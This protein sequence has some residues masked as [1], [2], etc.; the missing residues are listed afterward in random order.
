MLDT[1]LGLQTWTI[2]CHKILRVIWCILYASYYYI[3]CFFLW[4]GVKFDKYCFNA[5]YIRREIVHTAGC[6]RGIRGYWAPRDIQYWVIRPSPLRDH[7]TQ[8]SPARKFSPFTQCLDTLN[9]TTT[10]TNR[11][12]SGLAGWWERSCWG[13]SLRCSW[14]FISPNTSGGET[15]EEPCFDKKYFLFWG[16]F[17]QILCL[18]LRY[19]LSAWQHSPE[20]RTMQGLE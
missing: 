18:Q 6:V 20:V 10:K 5:R 11:V 3:L 8:T 7:S 15:A 1:R 16:N 12:L 2:F 9:I 19:L 13:C 14:L 4:L 17:N